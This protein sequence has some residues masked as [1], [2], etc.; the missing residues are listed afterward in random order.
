[1][2]QQT[3]SNFGQAWPELV[4]LPISYCSTRTVRHSLGMD[5]GD[6]GYWKVVTP[7]EVA[8][9]W[10]GH[11]VGFRSYRDQWMSEG[12]AH[13]S[14]SLYRSSSRRSRRSSPSSG[15]TSARSLTGEDNE[16]AF[17]PI[18]AGPGYDGLSPQQ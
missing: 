16:K 6:R 5:W 9:Q 14:A 12:F 13:M 2:T 7:H 10:W 3:A 8:H 1:M 17:R 15:R 11:T 18:D 4:Y